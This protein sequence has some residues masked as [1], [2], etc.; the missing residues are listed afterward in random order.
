MKNR[1]ELGWVICEGDRHAG[2]RERGLVDEAAARLVAEME[3]VF[4]GYEW[5]R[6][7]IVR[8]T[9]GRGGQFDPLELLAIGVRG[10]VRRGWDF[11][12]AGT[13]AELIGRRK[14]EL[15]DAPASA[16]EC[17][18]FSMWK[19]D[20]EGLGVE[21]LLVVMRYLLGGHAGAEA[22]PVGGKIQGGR[23][24]GAAGEAARYRG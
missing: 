18:V 1:I 11:A 2:G 22:G 23:G 13:A 17:G 8:R 10:K 12:M 24:D 20:R 5:T 9:P 16:L 6:E 19:V 21:G 4:P 15:E 14:V 3:E 7:V